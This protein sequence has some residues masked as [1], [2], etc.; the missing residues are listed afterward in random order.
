MVRFFLGNKYMVDYSKRC[1][2][3]NGEY[4]HSSASCKKPYYKTAENK[5][6]LLVAH[7]IS[8]YG[9]IINSSIIL[10]VERY[11][12]DLV[13]ESWTESG[14]FHLIKNSS[15]NLYYWVNKDKTSSYLNKLDYLLK[16]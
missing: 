5:H 3:C 8:G 7:D 13:T 4:G 6:F 2:R 1:V 16:M 12:E 14:S 9:A 10:K 15:D 11:I